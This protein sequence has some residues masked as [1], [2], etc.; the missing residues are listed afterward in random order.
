MDVTGLALARPLARLGVP[1]I[2]VDRVRRR[3]AGYSG[4]YRLLTTDQF[5]EDEAFVEFL[6]L[7]AEDLPRRAALLLSMDHHVL[8]VGRF[9]QRLRDRYHFEFPGP[10][11]VELLM[12]KGRF[13]EYA[14]VQG[15]PIPVSHTLETPEELAALLPVLQFPVV[16]KPQLKNALLRS[17][18]PRKV[19]RCD[20]RDQLISA[21]RLMSQWQPAGVVQEWIPGGDGEIFFSMHYLDESLSEVAGFEGRKIRQHLPQC[22]S[23]SSAVAVSEEQVSELT[24]K[25]LR[26]TRCVGF[27]AVE[28][29]RDHRNGSFH[30]MEPTVGRVDLQ[31]GVAAANK[32]GF[33]SRAYFHLIG[34]PHPADPPSPKRGV[35]L[36]FPRDFR[37]ARHEMKRRE[38]TWLGYLRSLWGSREFAVWSWRDLPLVRAYAWWG[39]TLPFRAARFFLRRL[40]VSP[41]VQAPE[42]SVQPNSAGAGESHASPG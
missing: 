40:L 33:V 27:G 13:A 41:R 15:W 18:S 29:K 34:H 32:Y 26:D 8:A 31:V 19:F 9:G 7:L 1:V 21:Y 28:Y 11:A 20:G 12:N 6:D 17:Y 4:S 22:G 39:L 2:G 36:H 25:I 5:D 42:D 14:R 30:I 37:T 38:L 24:L 10:D 35:W 3:F 16:L 23:T